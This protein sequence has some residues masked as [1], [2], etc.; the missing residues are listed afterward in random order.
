MAL[1]EIKRVTSDAIIIATPNRY[2]FKDVHDT[3][4]KFVHWMPRHLGIK[5]S[6]KFSKEGYS[7]APLHSRFLSHLE[8]EN[9]LFDFKL[10]TP[11]SCFKDV[12]E[13]RQI[14]PTYYPY[15]VGG[16]I[17]SSGITGIK[18]NLL[19]IM[20]FIGK[21]SRYFLPRIQGIYIRKNTK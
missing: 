19:R 17:T 15:G 3:G 7:H 11:F 2:Y 20:F 5:Y 14:F 9:I 16:G 6:L 21:N 4:L 13:Y 12:E 1:K 18:L 10:V 8:L